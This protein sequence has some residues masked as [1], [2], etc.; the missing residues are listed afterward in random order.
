MGRTLHSSMRDGRTGGPI[1]RRECDALLKMTLPG[2]SYAGNADVVMF[3]LKE[4]QAGL[5]L[6]QQFHPR[7]AHPPDTQGMM[8]GSGQAGWESRRWEATQLPTS[9]RLVNGTAPLGCC[10]AGARKGLHPYVGRGSLALGLS[11]PVWGSWL[12]P[13]W[14]RHLERVS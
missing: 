12:C 10:A 11:C 4:T 8:Q 13:Y 6:T 1:H 3:R 5:R 9:G 2:L 14:P 7:G